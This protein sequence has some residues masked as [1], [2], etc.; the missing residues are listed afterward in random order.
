[1]GNPRKLL[2][3]VLTLATPTVAA[4]QCLPTKEGTQPRFSIIISAPQPQA[5][6]GALITVK[7]SMTNKSDR[8]ISI[9]R[10][11]G[12]QGGRVYKVDVHDDTGKTA[13]ETKLGFVLNGH[14]DRSQLSALSLDDLHLGF[15]GACVVLK[16]GK[17]LTDEVN[18]SRLYDLSKPGKYS[19]QLSRLDEGSGTFVKSNTLNVAVTP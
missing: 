5:V 6:A 12:E 4:A 9:W 3:L 18:V 14:A 7:V 11:N 8:D 15:S 16:S 19:I 13:T 10:E 17:T 1:M 2:V